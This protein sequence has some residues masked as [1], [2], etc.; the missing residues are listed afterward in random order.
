MTKGKFFKAMYARA[1]H[2]LGLAQ[3]P[4]IIG[5][6]KSSLGLDPYSIWY[7]TGKSRAGKVRK[8]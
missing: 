6:F 4:L 7:A 1:K 2:S 3:Q 8:M 5:Y